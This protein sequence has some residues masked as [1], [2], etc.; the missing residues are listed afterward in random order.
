MQTKLKV[1][2][3]DHLMHYVEADCP[4]GQDLLRLRFDLGVRQY[5]KVTLRFMPS[6]WTWSEEM[7]LIPEGVQ[8]AEVELKGMPSGPFVLMA[9][10]FDE[11]EKPY[12]GEGHTVASHG[13]RRLLDKMPYLCS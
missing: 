13:E 1:P 12:S 5:A 10:F 6:G 3:R 8:T 11:H 4:A 9:T 7:G 2:S